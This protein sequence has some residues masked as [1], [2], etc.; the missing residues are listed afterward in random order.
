MKEVEYLG[1][2]VSGARIVA[3]PVKV[4][5]VQNFPTR[6]DVKQVRGSRQRSLVWA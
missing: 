2:R 4:Q 1:Y 3:D 5:A 6:V